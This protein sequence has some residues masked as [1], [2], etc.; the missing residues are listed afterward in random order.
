MNLTCDICGAPMEKVENPI[1]PHFKCTKCEQ[2]WFNSG[3]GW[4]CV[5]IKV[6]WPSKMDETWPLYRAKFLPSWLEGQ[7]HYAALDLAGGLINEREHAAKV[8]SA[9]MLVKEWHS[10]HPMPRWKW[11]WYEAKDVWRSFTMPRRP[12]ITVEVSVERRP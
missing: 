2:S 9:E 8:A 1:G 12:K 7:K 3:R 10:K 5:I 4:S 11:L 6:L